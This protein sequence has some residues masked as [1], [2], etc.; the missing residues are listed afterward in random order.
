[1]ADDQ[2]DDVVAVWGDTALLEALANK[3]VHFR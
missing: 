1:V 2:F 3:T